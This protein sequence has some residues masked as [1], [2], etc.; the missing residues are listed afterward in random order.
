MTTD[1][2]IK[3]LCSCAKCHRYFQPEE[4]KTKMT[5]LYGKSVEEKVTPCCGVTGFTRTDQQYLL[6]RYD[7]IYLANNFDRF[8]NINKG[9][10]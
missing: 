10:Y 1:D 7:P 2:E 6:N 3:V 4:L 5:S 8:T 9:D